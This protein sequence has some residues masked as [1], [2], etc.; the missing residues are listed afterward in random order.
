MG[1]RG[2]GNAGCCCWQEREE[3]PGRPAVILRALSRKKKM[4]VNSRSLSVFLRIVL[5]WLAS[6]A[7]LGFY[8]E[9]GSRRE[10]R[11][12]AR[13]TTAVCRVRLLSRMHVYCCA[14]YSPAD[15]DPAWQETSASIPSP[16]GG[17]LRDTQICGHLKKWTTE[18][19]TQER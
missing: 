1:R 18:N 3:N 15:Q 7:R 11:V 9:A 8:L 12:C 17:V 13:G 14:L 16:G 19:E 4:G 5:L 10:R 2:V 6:N